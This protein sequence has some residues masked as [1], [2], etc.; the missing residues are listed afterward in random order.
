MRNNLIMKNFVISL[1]KNNL[2]NLYYYHNF[3]HTLYVFEQALEIG[4]QEKCTEEELDL[5][6]AAA[7][8]HDTGYLKTYNK[9]EEESCLFARQYLPEYGYGA[10]EIDVICEMIMATRIPQFPKTKLGEIL[11]DADLEYLGNESFEVKASSLFHEM[12]TINPSLTEA[13]WD[14]MQ[15]S[16]IQ[17]H[18]YFTRYCKANKEPVKQVHLNK[19]MKNIQ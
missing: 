18:H 9:H 17:K 5:L 11:A 1:L 8:W 4:R 3:E 15:I 12:H 16:F 19:L 7:L 6:G 10:T 2:S 14:E 13:K